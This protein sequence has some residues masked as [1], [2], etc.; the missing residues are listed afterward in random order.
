M[1]HKYFKKEFSTHLVG[2]CRASVSANHLAGEGFQQ[3]EVTSGATGKRHRVLGKPAGEASPGEALV[4]TH[5]IWLCPH[6]PG[7][8]AI[9]G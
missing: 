1:F 7:V 3:M 2:V 6:S 4:G 5:C 8:P 9:M